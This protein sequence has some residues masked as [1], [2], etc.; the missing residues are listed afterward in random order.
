MIICIGREFGSGGHEIGLRLAEMLDIPFYD[1]KLIDAA[2]KSGLE[3]VVLENAD[4]K[5]TNFW[6]HT[7]QYNVS[8]K[9]F[10]GLPAN[11]ILFQLQSEF[12][13]NTAKAGGG[14]FVGRCSDFV[15]EQAGIARL[16]LFIS[17]PFSQRVKR[18]MEL[19]HMGEKEVTALVRKTDK[20][21]KAYYDY[22]TGNS[23]GKP[24]NYDI[25][26]N[27]ATFGIDGTANKLNEFVRSFMGNSF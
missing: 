14:V 21:R 16:S 8:E 10:R 22:H 27:S 24:H 15:L 19:L 13:L 4:E 7:A 3:T 25:C 23:W 2:E 18:K 11:D 5:N 12:I 20:K 1:R 17:A 9:R 26:I 6:L